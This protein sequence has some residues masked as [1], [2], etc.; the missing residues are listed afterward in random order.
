MSKVL[1]TEQHLQD[2]ADAIRSKSGGGAALKVSDMAQAITD[3]PEGGSALELLEEI[4]LTEEQR[5]FDIDTTQYVQEYDV[6]IVAGDVTVPQ[7]DWIY[8]TQNGTSGGSYTARINEYTGLF[9]V[10]IRKFQGHNVITKAS[11]NTGVTIA[12][13][14]SNIYIYC[15]EATKAFGVGS[16]VK[17]YGAKFID[18]L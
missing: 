1:V 11:N 18:L 15:Y 12:D 14:L 13:T 4:T 9:A 10:W 17:V 5:A 2:I 16:N 6:L 3:L 8:V 7:Y